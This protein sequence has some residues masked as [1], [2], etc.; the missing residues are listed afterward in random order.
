MNM[1]KHVKVCHSNNKSNGIIINDNYEDVTGSSDP[2]LWKSGCECSFG[3]QGRW[4]NPESFDAHKRDSCHDHLEYLNKRV[5][6]LEKINESRMNKENENNDK[7]VLMVESQ[8][9]PSCGPFKNDAKMEDMEKNRL[10]MSQQMNQQQIEFSHQHSA[11][12]AVD[13]TFLS[14]ASVSKSNNNY[15]NSARLEL[16]VHHLSTRMQ[17]LESQQQFIV[18]SDSTPLSNATSLSSPPTTAAVTLKEDVS[19]M[20]LKKLELCFRKAETYEGMAMVLNVS[21]D[22]L[23]N[24]VTEFDNQRRRGEESREAQERKIQVQYDGSKDNLDW[25]IEFK[26]YFV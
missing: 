26:Y 20:A 16:E 8:Q 21:L 5:V 17:T 12:G 23:L 10:G 6:R 11:N 13:N 18:R 7:N 24:Q 25:L 1:V 4:Y 22:R 2:A 15:N 14:S 19:G 9:Q 3:C